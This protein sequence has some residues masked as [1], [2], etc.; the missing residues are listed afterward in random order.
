LKIRPTEHGGWESFEFDPLVNP[1]AHRFAD[2]ERLTHPAAA[3]HFEFFLDILSWKPVLNAE[4]Q[5]ALTAQLLLQ[6]RINEALTRFDAID[7]AGLTSRMAYDYLRAVVLFHRSQAE[8]ARVIAQE[9]ATLPPGLWKDRFGKVIAQ[10]DEIVALQVP[11][12]AEERKPGEE[13]PSL[14]LALSPDGKLL[15]RQHK[16]D[17]TLLQLFSV[18]LEV[19]FS[20]DP[21]LAGD[22]ASLPGI[23]ANDTREVVLA[24]AETSVELPENFRKGNVLVAAR[25]GGTKMLKVLDSRALE[26]IRQPQHRTLQVFDSSSRLPLPRC[27][28]KV[29]VRGAG[30]EARFHK[31]GYTDLRGKFDYLSH[32]GENLGEIRKISVLISHPEKGARIEVFDL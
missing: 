4:D 29:Y 28:V 10:A 18:D 26:M 8:E 11:H 24:A 6:D 21:F 27:Y 25:S 3:K 31:D 9:Y 13:A 1:R 2:Q 30:G 12:K 15:L 19:L 16:L 32:T 5:L 22:G 23:R 17:K 20:K 7:P 14:D